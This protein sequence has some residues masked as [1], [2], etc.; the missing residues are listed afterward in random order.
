[1]GG[2]RQMR[3]AMRKAWRN[4]SPSEAASVPWLSLDSW[5]VLAA[6]LAAALIRWGLIPRVPW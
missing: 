3:K 4:R 2:E 5:A 1:M 6:L